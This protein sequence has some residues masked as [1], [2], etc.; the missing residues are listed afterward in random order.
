MEPAA[1]LIDTGGPDD[2]V[3]LE[4]LASDEDPRF[5]PS[6]L[7]IASMEASGGGSLDRPVVPL[8]NAFHAR[9]VETLES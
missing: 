6:M 5:R 9:G 7:L 8:L 2:N 1:Y 3:P 4:T